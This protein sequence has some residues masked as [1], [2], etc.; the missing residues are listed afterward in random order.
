MKSDSIATAIEVDHDELEQ[1]IRLYWDAKKS[2]FIWG[3][4]GIGK[5]RKVKDTFKKIASE[6]K[7]EYSEEITDINKEGKLL[8]IDVRLSQ[9]DPSDLRGIPVWDKEKGA[10]VWL[11][12]DSFPRKGVGCIFF[13]EMNLA[14]PIVQASAYQMILDRRLGTYVVPQNFML[15]AA[16]N[17]LEDRAN[18]F[19]MA[20]PLKNRFG[21]VQL[22]QPDMEAWTRWGA[23]NGIDVRIIGFLNWRPSHIFTF[24]PKLKESAFATPRSWEATS[25]LIKKV[26]THNLGLIQKI[27]STQVGVGVAGELATFI[28]IKDKLRPIE[29]Y[30]KEPEKTPIPTEEETDLLWALVTSIAEYYSVHNDMKSLGQVFKLIKRFNEE[31]A[32]FT[33]KLMVA[34]DK[35]V[36]L[37]IVKLDEASKLAKKLVDFFE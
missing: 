31:F 22:M 19:E 11:P 13:D 30:I 9:M 23:Q 37:K 14:A 8:V 15:I 20:A 12:P 24:D 28:K 16:G 6:L 10:T 29:D 33:L 25:D 34:V 17:R 26:P 4:T 27:A 32:V 1:M 21:H 7:L 18:V 35:Q 2:L 36:P 5:S 3:S